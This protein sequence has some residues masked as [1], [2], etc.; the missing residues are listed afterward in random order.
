MTDSPPFEEVRTPDGIPV[1]ELVRAMG[2][3]P[4]RYAA[5]YLAEVESASLAELADVVTG[6]VNAESGEIA[7]RTDR[8]RIRIHLYHVA[9][10]RLSELDVVAFDPHEKTASIEAPRETILAVLD[11]YD[12]TDLMEAV[13]AED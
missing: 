10:P 12:S 9:L 5:A 11:W 1:G 4:A 7:S 8:D 2:D 3:P 13:D 6:W